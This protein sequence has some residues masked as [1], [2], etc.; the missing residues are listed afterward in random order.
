MIMPTPQNQI[1]N[2][3]PVDFDPFENGPL[4]DVVPAIEPQREIFSSFLVGGED[5]NR[6]YNQS[7]SLHFTGPFN[8]LAFQRALN[9]LID[10]HE[11][12][13]SN[14]SADGNNV[15]IYKELPLDFV[16]HELVTKNLEDR[17]NYID[18]ATR[19]DAQK[20]FDLLNG[21]L[22][23]TALFHISDQEN[24]VTITA[25]HII[26][27]G[28]S[29]GVIIR[30]L[31]KLYS[32]FSR[33]VEPDLPGAPKF[34]DYAMQQIAFSKSD[35]FKLIEQYWINQYSD[36]VPV[37]DLP[38]I[39]D[40]PAERSYKSSNVRFNLNQQVVS[41]IR[42]AGV[43]SGST[44]ATT[45][46]AAFE[47]FLHG[48]TRQKNVVV[49]IPASGQS[50]SGYH[51]L[52]G[53]CVN[54]LPVKS[55]I[56]Q[57][58]SFSDFLRKQK[59]VIL[60]AYD[61]QFLTFGSL[62]KKLRIRRDPSRIPLVPVVLNIDLVVDSDVSFF[63]LEHKVISNAKA[64]E[65]FEIFLNVRAIDETLELEWIYNDRLF[66]KAS[67]HQMMLDFESVLKAIARDPS[68]LICNIP[69]KCIDN[70]LDWQRQWIGDVVEYDKAVPVHDLIAEKAQNF[71]AHTAI[72]FGEISI[73]YGQLNR[74]SN[75][76]A[77]LLQSK[78]VSAGDSVGLAM[79]RSEKTV[80]TLLA[81][82]KTGACYIPIDPEYPKD[83]IEYMLDDSGA[84]I[85]IT[86][87]KYQN[88]F[89]TKA[90]EIVIEEAWSEL[91]SFSDVEISSSVRTGDELVYI[92]YT[93]GSTGKPKGVQI[94]HQNLSNFL[95]S[96]QQILGVQHNDRLLGV[97]TIS[98]DI[99]GLEFYLPLISGASLLIT[100]NET[101]KD[102]Y[103]LLDKI[104]SLRP[105]IMQA[106]PS[107]W[108]MLISSGWSEETKIDTILCGGEALSS[109]LAR[110]L[111]VRSSSLINVY[112]PT[113]TTIWSTYKKITTAEEIITIGRPIAN[114]QVFILDDSGKPVS[115]NVTG[116]IYIAGDG[117]A[118]GYLNRPELTAEKFLND[119][120]STEKSSRMYR[121]GDMGKY[122]TNGDVQ[123]LG[124]IDHQ[125]KIRGHR[126]ELSEIENTLLEQGDVE[127]AVVIAS[128]DRPGDQKLIAYIVLNKISN[129]GDHVNNWR[130]SLKR[131]LPG[132]MVPNDFVILSSFPLTPNGKIDRNALPKPAL[133]STIN[134][135]Q[136]LAPRSGMEALIA[137][138][139]GKLLEIEKVGIHDDFFELGGH[140]LIAGQVM[141]ILAKETGKRLPL[142]SLF[143]HPVLEEFANLFED[144]V[145]DQDP[146]FGMNP[147][148]LVKHAEKLYV[149]ATAPQK[150]IWTS[151]L[152]GG[153]DAN[154]SYNL[155]ISEKLSGNLHRLYFEKSLQEVIN[156]HQSLRSTFSSDGNTICISPV[157][158]PNLDY[159]DISSKNE[160]DQLLFIESYVKQIA[161]TPY[162]LVNGPLFKTAFFKLS[163][164]EHYFTFAVHHI[165]CDGWSLG[166]FLQELSKI[167]SAH[168]KD[169][170]LNIHSAPG[171]VNYAH[172]E[173]AFN[174]SK[175][176]RPIEEYWI[177]QYKD[178]V[179]V[180][181]IPT[182]F[183]RPASRT[184]K[185]KRDDYPL[186]TALISSIN[187]IGIQS[188]CSLSI[189]LRAA[190]E[191]F[192]CH[193]T[194]QDDL[195]V[196]I[197]TAGQ[198]ASENYEL[199]A[200]CA[201][202][203]PL[204]A[205][206][207]RDDS[208]TNYL[209]KRKQS[210][211]DAYENQRFTFSSL[212]QKLN[213]PRDKSRLPL[214]PVVFN[215]E[216]GMDDGVNF[217][218]LK[219]EMTFHP[220][221]YETFEI[222]LNIGGSADRPVLQWSYNTQ[223]FTTHTIKRM[224]ADYEAVLQQL[225]RNASIRINEIT[226][227]S[228]SRVYEDSP[229]VND[230]AVLYQKDK[231]LYTLITNHANVAGDQ[232]AIYFKDLVITYAELEKLSNNFAALLKESGVLPSD[233]IGVAMERSHK[234]VIVLLAIMKAGAV[235]IPL[236]PDFPKE[237]IEFMLED[238]NTKLLI[239]SERYRSH[240]KSKAREIIIDDVWNTLS[241]YAELQPEP[242]IPEGALAYILYTSGS[243]GKPKGVEV[244]HSGLMN[245]LY[246]MQKTLAVHPGDKLLAVTTISFD[247]SGL[248]LFLPLISGASMVLAES[249]MV[250]DGNVLLEAIKI[251][252]PTI[253]QATP[254]T[255]QMLLDAGWNRDVVIP[256]IC[257]GG[258]ALSKELA[259]QLNQRS[260]HL[261]N[262]Y[263]PTETTIWSTVKKVSKSDEMITIGK[264]IDNT[265]IY[266]VDTNLR[267][268]SENV[269]G[270]ICIG[271][272]GLAQ[273]Y[274][275]RP[276][277][278][279][280]KFIINPFSKVPGEKIYRTG[281]LGRL[282]ANGEIEC[283]GRA[284]Q[285]IK[286]RGYRI[287]P[288]EIEHCL[289]QQHEI[290]SAVVIAREDRPG[291]QRLVAYV[292]LNEGIL[293]HKRM[294]KILTNSDL[295]PVHPKV[296]D[297]ALRI[298]NWK[299]ALRKTLPP[300][301]IPADFVV[302]KKFPLTPNGK[303]DRK[304]LPRPEH[305]QPTPQGHAAP[306]SNEERLLA[307]IWGRL[308]NVEEVSITD[309][310]FEIGGH[311][312]L[313]IQ[314]MT[315]IENKTGIR[316]PVN[317]LFDNS[318]IEKLALKL[319]PESKTVEWKSL[320]PIKP[321]GNRLPIYFA[322]EIG[323]RVFYLMKMAKLV[324]PQQPIYGLQGR[325]LNGEPLFESIE[326][327][328]RHYVSE[329]VKHNPTGP[330]L[331]AGYSYGGLIAYEM[332]QQLKA[333]GKEVKMLAI[334][335]TSVTHLNPP[336]SRLNRFSKK[337]NE[338]IMQ[339]IFLTIFF[340]RDPK[341]MI[342]REKEVNMKKLRIVY[343]SVK[344]FFKIG[345]H[346]KFYTRYKLEQ[347][348]LDAE[349]NYKIAAYDGPMQLFRCQKKLYYIDDFEYLGW[350][351]YV[352]NIQVHN[353]PGDHDRLFSYPYYY[354][355]APSLQACLDK[356][357]LE[358][359]KEI[360]RDNFEL[361]VV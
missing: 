70:A 260:N 100:D 150:E 80:I 209:K 13:R 179:P 338:V 313:A 258:E 240:F 112:G 250:R 182:D 220:R 132:Y 175:E 349:K 88:Q 208:F 251:H 266:I 91:E 149:A 21:P 350:R 186:D 103:L 301:M 85:L 345:K 263:G 130:A 183:V 236:D 277:L 16:T 161:D 321:S 317:V 214:V 98:F 34:S 358:Q 129:K 322:H 289:V 181:D 199:I 308:L 22:F 254:V 27:D 144:K 163:D 190:F 51:G 107:T 84:R 28:W 139:W 110:N 153:D 176:Y 268:V 46:I 5:A 104:K 56:D 49:G 123:C 154:R 14:F 32:C 271:G 142:T 309:D 79:D 234:T 89:A 160:S 331:L 82:M 48:I 206:V 33:N 324:H 39:Q 310:F 282:L 159:R 332:A 202:L 141:T 55:S 231:P 136:Y 233:K 296:K 259:G 340:F 105:T 184:Y 359:P 165:I 12:L 226:L 173:L 319:N 116:E 213:V 188:G 20:S 50:A 62:L 83:R 201:N 302:L 1:K 174:S 140:S 96:M 197:P 72:R 113:E 242:V 305:S 230:T 278:T 343:Y 97:T 127:Q 211:L 284:D 300:Y 99:S 283:L 222:F 169:E 225:V 347:Q 194:G 288:G 304:E 122:L 286:I 355:V 315:Q 38:A 109:D 235:Y 344:A 29:L 244:F 327:M 25:H 120:F 342:R 232:A 10:R 30:D 9:A 41:G 279:S 245:F 295:L 241:S 126:I 326:E 333:M 312:L 348:Y 272:D 335:D 307:D 316:V 243:T 246:S 256:T 166:I 178:G 6:S 361:K 207:D 61:H 131:V 262:L 252:R 356:V 168:V 298:E 292:V 3:V 171:F 354:T 145:V 151:C 219:H 265:Q 210:T 128:E 238:S 229:G 257:C 352:Q 215:A 111:L 329:I 297:D 143:R 275:N 224:M 58:I 336:A 353:V 52:V 60:N 293:A 114:T 196:G 187:K 325:G 71:Q 24:Y 135:D 270:E 2:L 42:K 23:R 170:E 158:N 17:K 221:E 19:Q 195:V 108:Q 138:T 86:S 93:S 47:V 320:V 15:C 164:T 63:N 57:S 18:E 65:S 102:G 334:F 311:S 239:T 66:S 148:Q 351:N 40:R 191:I 218:G 267:P 76:L 274:Y 203:L 7:V 314:M 323:G 337:I 146:A 147:E 285:Q 77:S 137:N 253:M 303:I 54:L 287:E 318:T 11:I 68:I 249:S 228:R 87:K 156:R 124:R 280:E 133:Q 290:K 264:P 306:R 204:R 45:L 193:L 294:R 346:E 69:L 8:R 291:D 212:L 185:S 64:Y 162:D 118:K 227:L 157:A 189:T 53:N 37:L 4:M 273:G 192:L 299:A 115:A 155:A 67:I 101:A 255:W 152:M 200:H 177:N 198:L 261:F 121:T 276:E 180:L 74:Q 357:V 339:L 172:E 75:R 125:V 43:Q 35:R 36:D 92:L 216:M 95:L 44:M 73:T 59:Q 90:K 237:R 78:G 81:I 281:D 134:K 330:Y 217:H 31:S 269:V 167:Y 223:L 248:E 26:C 328:A 247:I 94:T 106:T 205:R 119:T 341:T 117:V 360:Y